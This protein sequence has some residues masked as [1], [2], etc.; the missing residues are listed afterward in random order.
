MSR[1]AKSRLLRV[2]FVATTV[3]VTSSEQASANPPAIEK[4]PDPFVVAPKVAERPNAVRKHDGGCFVY[5]PSGGTAKVDCP[6]E[7]LAPEPRR[8]ASSARRRQHRPC[9]ARAS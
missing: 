5:Y 7:L 2:E 1:N 3:A 4:F 9:A 6:K 8:T